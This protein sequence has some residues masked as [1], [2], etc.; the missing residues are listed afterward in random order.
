MFDGIVAAFAP[1]LLDV[2][3]FA[4]YVQSEIQPPV[5]KRPVYAFRP[6]HAWLIATHKKRQCLG[7]L[8]FLEK[9]FF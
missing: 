2:A 9:V 6:V 7:G 5:R 1:L 8:S 3:V 4:V